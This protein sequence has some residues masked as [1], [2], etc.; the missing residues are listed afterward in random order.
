MRK[1]PLVLIS[2]NTINGFLNMLNGKNLNTRFNTYLT[3]I[4]KHSKWSWK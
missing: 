4:S 3:Y 2:I 1:K